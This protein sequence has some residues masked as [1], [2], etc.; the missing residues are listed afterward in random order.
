MV[1]LTCILTPI[2]IAIPEMYKRPLQI[3]DYTLSLLFLV[4]IVVNFCS[5]YFDDDYV[6]IENLQVSS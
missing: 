1:I 6:L 3:A 4:D 5:A 2:N